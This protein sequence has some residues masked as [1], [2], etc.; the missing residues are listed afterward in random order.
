MYPVRINMRY[1]FTILLSASVPTKERSEEFRKIPCA[2]IQ[3]EQAV[4]ALARNVFEVGGRMI[5]GGHPSISPLVA[6][7]ATE[8]NLN[9]EIES[10]ERNEPQA[11]PVSIYQSR[12]F[13]EVIPD[14]TFTL[15]NLGYAKIIWTNAV[16]G[17]KCNPSI[18]GTTQCER[19]LA[20]MRKEMIKENADAL[21]CIGGM[22]GVVE[23]FDLFREKHPNKPIYLFESTGGAS[24]NLAGKY[25][26]GTNVKV[27]DRLDYK[28]ISR[29]TRENEEQDNEREKIEIIPFT[30]MTA[31][32]VR[33][34]LE[35]NSH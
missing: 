5:F 35:R 26:N 19:S 28:F 3:I 27:I 30:F 4:I 34:L 1:K 31:L 16:N 24:R 10:M 11:K 21:V 9:K 15:F 20:F 23:E 2:Q 6:M 13:E 32:I 8:F 12:A 29:D 7:V 25:S 14:E 18:K 22:E 33:D 17:E